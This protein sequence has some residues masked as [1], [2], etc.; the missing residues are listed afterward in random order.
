MPLLTLVRQFGFKVSPFE[1][2]EPGALSDGELSLH[3]LETAAAYADRAPTYRFE[4]Q[5]TATGEP[6]GAIELRIG[7]SP[8]ILR[9]TG[10][11]GY[12]VERAHRGHRYAARACRLLFPLARRHQFQELWVTCDHDNAASFR[13]CELIGGVHVETVPVP[14]SHAYYEMGSRAKCR[15]RVTL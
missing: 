2:V 15:F 12:R 7:N 13:T 6:I 14:R 8:E 1:F 10:H 3:L 9:F 11:I 5:Y 4:M